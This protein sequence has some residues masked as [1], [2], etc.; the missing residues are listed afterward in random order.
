MFARKRG[1]DWPP[2]Q[3][4]TRPP[5]DN[6]DLG[7]ARRL[8][9]WIPPA[10]AL[11]LAWRAHARSK[12]Q[13]AQEQRDS[14]E[15]SL[16]TRIADLEQA[17]Q[18]AELAAWDW[19]IQTGEFR[20]NERWNEIRGFPPGP[21]PQAEQSW[22]A[23]IHPEDRPIVERAL[24]DHFAGRRP[25]Y[26]VEVRVATRE[27]RWVWI[28][29]RAKLCASDE[30][31][32]PLRMAGISRDIT[33][34]KRLEFEQRFLADLGPQIGKSLR[35]E[36]T[37]AAI[38]GAVTRGFGDCCVVDLIEDDGDIRRASV[39]CGPPSMWGLAEE[40]QRLPLDRKRPMMVTQVLEKGISVIEEKVNSDVLRYWAQ[41]R[42]SPFSGP[43]K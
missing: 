22:Y 12:L 36:E 19:N 14:R 28:L 41:T 6:R 10:G 25:D 1:S 34:Q 32:R 37:I 9:L 2:I 16:H 7:L 11:L 42:V 24:A 26:V 13:R 17:I 8:L 21:L 18:G 23:G 40:F 20:H 4:W 39:A 33:Q 30:R 35:V 27:G 38:S 3:S 43:E 31:G 29:Q 5:E 15:S